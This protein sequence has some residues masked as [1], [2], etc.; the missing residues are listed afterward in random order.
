MADVASL[1]RR[2]EVL[3][4]YDIAHAALEAGQAS[5]EIVNTAVLCLARANAV[6]FARSEYVR[7]GLD[8]VR[9]DPA[10]IA[11][12]ARL[13]K[14]VALAARG[15]RRA[16][17]ARAST[18]RYGELVSR[19]GGFYTSD[20]STPSTPSTRPRRTPGLARSASEPCWR[21]LRDPGRT[22]ATPPTVSSTKR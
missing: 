9:D 3:A 21:T 12:G 20:C 1:I 13:L 7:L 16:A 11:L 18:R 5:L 8:K 6:D 2:G 19:F 4:A 22:A 15:A 17:F 14:D 10:T